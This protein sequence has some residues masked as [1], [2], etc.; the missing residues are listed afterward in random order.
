MEISNLDIHES[1]GKNLC[2]LCLTATDDMDVIPIFATA[3]SN[4]ASSLDTL[5]R[6]CIA[7]EVSKVSWFG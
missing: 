7:L 4:R 1:H 3:S 6:D 2:R 5:I